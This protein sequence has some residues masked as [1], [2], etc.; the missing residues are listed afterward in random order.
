MA[1]QVKIINNFLDGINNINHIIER[2][3]LGPQEELLNMIEELNRNWGTDFRCTPTF[4]WQPGFYKKLTE[5]SGR[6]S[7]YGIQKNKIS[8]YRN[9][10]SNAR[11]QADRFLKKINEID[12]R[13]YSLRTSGIIFQDN[14]DEVN[15]VLSEYISTITNSIDEAQTLYPNIDINIFQGNWDSGYNYRGQSQIKH[16]ITFSIRIYGVNT[17]INIGDETVNIPMGDIE[18]IISVD[19]LKNIMNRIRA[20]RERISYGHSQTGHSSTWNG[21][22]FKSQEPGVLFPYISNIVRWNDGSTVVDFNENISKRY[23]GICFGSFSDQIIEAA[24]KGDILAL[25]TY[26]DAWTKNFNVGRTSPLNGF[27]KMFHGKWPEMTSEAWD[28]VS[29]MRAHTRMLECKYASVLQDDQ[30]AQDESY[31]NRYNCVLQD[32]CPTYQAMYH[33]ISKKKSD[34][35]IEAEIVNNDGG[36]LADRD[37]EGHPIEPE[38]LTETEILAMY[39]GVQTVDINPF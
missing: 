15:R 3:A 9:K 11:W 26:L 20:S 27:D 19:L 14:S 1:S 13:L 8:T 30:P 16:C 7:A 38:S 5:Q 37:G 23:Y 18:I 22:I 21:G 4:R 12:N 24:W 36:E 33:P 31:C 10:I 28:A 25:F 35:E 32:T 39:Q 6:I 2:V 34:M 17:N 29:S